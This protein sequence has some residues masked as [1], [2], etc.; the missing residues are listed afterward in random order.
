MCNAAFV[1]ETYSKRLNRAS[2][3]EYQKF[4]SGYRLFVTFSGIIAP[5]VLQ[6]QK[7]IHSMLSL[8][9]AMESGAIGL[10]LS[11]SGT[12]L[13]SRRQ[14]AENLDAE[15]QEGLKQADSTIESQNSII[16][17]LRKP[18]RSP[19]GQQR[20]EEAVES[21]GRLDRNAIAVLRHLNKHGL[22]TLVAPSVGSHGPPG[23]ESPLPINF[24]PTQTFEC[25]ESCARES[26]VTRSQRTLHLTPNHPYPVIYLDY[27]IAEGMKEALDELLYVSDQSRKF[28]IPPK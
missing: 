17:D 3:R 23:S 19:G 28:L 7:G 1:I 15:L 16:Q 22:L 9:E 13:Y 8:A 14:G 27:K 4:W 21:L 26:L 2:W 11:L 20:Y 12:Y 25:L 10:I 5:A 24:S 6:L 18:L